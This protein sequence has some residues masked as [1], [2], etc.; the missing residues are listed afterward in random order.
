MGLIKKV[1]HWSYDNLIDY[2]SVNPTRDEVSLYK[3]DPENE[4][5]ESIMKLRTVKDFGS[6]TCLD[7]SE[8]EI[9]MIG[10]GEKNGYLRI[11]NISGSNFSSLTN[12]ALASSNANNDGSTAN[13]GVSKSIQ[14]E[15][16]VGSISNAKDTV[17][18]TESET[19][20]DIRVR[21][22]KQRCIN[23]LGINTNGLIAMGLDRNKHDSS[24]QIWDMNYHDD[25]QETINPMFSYCI[26]ESIV[27]LKF[28]NDTSILA[29]STKFLKEI[30][31]RSSSPIYQHPTR[32]TYDIKLNPF[33]DWQ[34][35][36]YGDDGT[37]AI[38]DRR[39]LS[40]QVTLSDLNVA[41]PLLAFEKLVGSGAASRKYMNSCFRW[42]CIR[43]NEF[44]TLHRGDTIKRWRLGHYA[45][46]NNDTD[47]KDRQGENVENIFVS[48]VHDTNTMYDRVATFDYI[49]T[50][51][52]GTSLICMR[53]SG[54]IYRM[55]IPEICSKAI[56]NNRNSL[57]LSNF[58]NPEIEEIRVTNEHEKSNLENVKTVLKNLS[59]EDLVLVTIIFHLNMMSN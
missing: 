33:N 39:K 44:A 2:L 23:S 56:L 25:S 5:D 8:S 28:L 54:T 22:K 32:L 13:A 10:V 51:N 14:A 31:V 29:S 7:Y 58:E 40:D 57:L 15:N 27:S 17:G 43:N 12:Q 24:L 20:Y 9:G 1:T 19:N 52:R 47:T 16:T 36:T 53:Q 18:Y 45:V 34:F 42:S 55:P 26:N 3:V 6:I 4:S 30:D 35:S 37:L 49:P 50:G 41:S 59:F 21:A 48:S 11:F 46:D 38:W